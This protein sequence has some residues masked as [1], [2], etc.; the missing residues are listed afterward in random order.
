MPLPMPKISLNA[1]AYTNDNYLTSFPAGNAN[2]GVYSDVDSWRCIAAPAGNAAQGT[3]TQYPGFTTPFPVYLAY[4]LSGVAATQR[5]K[6]ML[7]WYYDTPGA[8]PYDPGIIA[9]NYANQARDYTIDVNAAAGGTL[10]TSGWVTKVTIT[11][12]TYHSRQHAF[13]MTGYNWVRLNATAAIGTASNNN[14]A[15]NMDI[16]DAHLGL[17]SWIFYGDSITQR[18]LDHDETGGI[19]TIVPAQIN[20]AKSAYYPIWECGG[21]GGFTAQD[22]V[23]YVANTFLPIFPGKYVALPLG[24]NDANGGGAL[25]PN[26]T[27]NMQSMITSILNAGKIPVIPHIPYGTTAN[28]IANGPT[29]NGYIDALIAANPGCIAGPDLW[30]YFQANQTLIGGD[31]IHPTDP[32]GYAAYR[33]Q[34]VNW[35]TAN[36]YNLKLM[37]TTAQTSYKIRQKLTTVAQTRFKVRQKLVTQARAA[38]KIQLATVSLPQP[39]MIT[40]VQTEMF[41]R[42]NSTISSVATVINESNATVDGLTATCLVTFP[43]GSTA[44]EQVYGLGSGGQYEIIYQTKGAGTITEVWTFIDSRGS[45]ATYSHKL[46]C[47]AG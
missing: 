27:S 47:Y 21:I 17:D 43:D 4:D 7:A 6:V 11:G 12:N 1:P 41:V 39:Y 2:D 31:G 38:F 16:H 44:T 19:G 26:F 45:V 15:M 36:V 34:W 18:G 9:N 35:A 42:P 24:T 23:G 20:A 25:L 10:P 8:G 37:Q 14:V 33:T 32:A 5:G 28:I 40:G 22:M 46:P 30:T 3:L 29:I 13:D